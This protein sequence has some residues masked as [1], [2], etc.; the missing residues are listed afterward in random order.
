MAI[1]ALMKLVRRYFQDT[2]AAAKD[3]Q[4]KRPRGRRPMLVQLEERRVFNATFLLNAGGLTLS[5]FDAN[6][7]LNISQNGGN[8]EFQLSGAASNNWA[9]ALG[10]NALSTSGGGSIITVSLRGLHRKRKFHRHGCPGR[11]PGCH[12]RRCCH[13]AHSHDRFHLRYDDRWTA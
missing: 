8:L 10:S 4:L 5:N 2:T 7:N 6:S 11:Q 13:A 12:H 1:S 3:T 9:P